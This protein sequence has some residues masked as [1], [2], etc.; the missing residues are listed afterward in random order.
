MSACKTIL[1]I[2]LLLTVHGMAGN[3]FDH[4]N[5]NFYDTVDLGLALNDKL[6]SLSDTE[7]RMA[8]AGSGMVLSAMLADRA[9]REWTQARQTTGRDRI[10]AIDDYYG[11]RWYMIGGTLTLYGLGWVLD[12]RDIRRTGLKSVQALLYTGLITVITKDVFGRSRPFRDEGPFTYRPLRFRESNRAFFSGHTSITFAVSTVMA[13]SVDHLLWKGLWYSAA[14]LT[15][16]ARIYHD[17]HWLSDVMAGAMVG[18]GVGRF[19]HRQHTTNGSSGR[20]GMGKAGMSLF[21]FSV[22]LR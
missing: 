16:M 13:Q 20:L 17:K 5:N 18:Y 2:V 11:D 19:V 3:R 14:V 7:T 15:G 12:N 1:F 10:F 9:V 6:F 21:T 22:P 8:L 4:L